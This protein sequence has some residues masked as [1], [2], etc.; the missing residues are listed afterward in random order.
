MLGTRFVREWLRMHSRQ[1]L[2][3]ILL[4]CFVVWLFS[5]AKPVQLISDRLPSDWLPPDRILP[6]V[7][8]QQTATPQP[9]MLL[10]RVKSDAE[11][12][13]EKHAVRV[14]ILMY[15]YIR[16]VYEPNDKSGFMLSVTPEHFEKQVQY[17]KEKGYTT[18]SPQQLYD[19]LFHNTPL[20]SKPVMLTFDDGYQDFYIEALRIIEKY[21]IKV[22]VF[23]PT[24]RINTPNYM[25]WD[26]VVALSKN[27][28]ITLAS[29]TRHHL[30]VAQIKVEQLDN[31]IFQS[32]L[33]LER[34]LG[35][36]IDFFAYP[37]GGFNDEVIK[38]V[39]KAS[40]KLAFSTIQGTMQS[41]AEQYFLRRV[42]ISGDCSLEKFAAFVGS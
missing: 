1:A 41:P 34:N 9:K 4:L 6:G 24:D 35:R 30:N 32:R 25:S 8:P 29:H 16:Y 28:N 17:L 20:P 19:N 11:I 12:A 40:Y 22:T 38:E 15:H 7:I 31:E 14:P 42:S 2:R 37:Y 33:I 36:S 27:P 21:N 5:G 18:I 23:I 13:A 26:Q 39:K 10:P 3:F